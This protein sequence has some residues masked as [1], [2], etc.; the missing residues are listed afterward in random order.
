MEGPADGIAATPPPGSL[1]RKDEGTR[2]SFESRVFDFHRSTYNS[3]DMFCPSMASRWP[4]A[5]NGASHRIS[6]SYIEE[7]LIVYLSYRFRQEVSIK[8]IGISWVCLFNG[9]QCYCS[10]WSVPQ[11]AGWSMIWIGRIAT[12][13]GR[14]AK[15]RGCLDRPPCRCAA[16]SEG[17]KPPRGAP[18]FSG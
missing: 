1:T 10:M 14:I 4:F 8:W 7:L 2:D 3:R 6:H 13:D 11:R 12:M 15:R 5:C 18:L 9:H 16:P 17:R